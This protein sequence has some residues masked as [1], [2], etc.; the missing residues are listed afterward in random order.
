ML[1]ISPTP[2][3]LER[4]GVFTLAFVLALLFQ[5]LDGA[6]RSEYGGHPDEAAHYVTGL[7]VRDYVAAHLPG[8]PLTYAQQYYDHYP[9]IGLGVW[10]PFFYAVQAAWTLPFGVGHRALL[11]LMA[12][13][14]AG[15]GLLLHHALREEAGPWIAAA[16]ALAWIALPL[17]RELYGMVMAETLS[18][19]LM[20]G[21]TLCFGRFLDDGRAR[22]VLLFGLLAALAIMS[23]GTGL[24]LGLMA[25]FALILSRQWRLL[26][27]PALWGGAAVTALLA[28][29]WT[30]K[31]REL[32]H[33]GWLQPHPSWSFTREAIPYYLVKFT[34]VGIPLLILL[35]IGV[36]S[37]F[38]R[39]P[40]KCGGALAALALLPAVMLFQSLAPVGLEARHLVPTLP[41]AVLLAALGAARLRLP[42]PAQP[43]LLLASAFLLPQHHPKACGGFAPL[44]E[45]LIGKVHPEEQILVASDATGEGMLI[46][47]IALRDGHRPTYVVQRASKALAA[48]EW[49]GRDY[50]AKFAD[51]AALQAFLMA[52]PIRYVVLDDSVPAAKRTPHEAQL[53][54]LMQHEPGRF[55]RLAGFRIERGSV[56]GDA[57]LFRINEDASK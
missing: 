23:K 35:A 43:A 3:S 56:A 33:G 28:G 36:W 39:S 27:R 11:V 14:A 4:V 38:A 52:S 41:A 26:R 1:P 50:H 42:R 9:K 25:A 47:E 29:P 32:G 10:P 2:R 40:R 13:L 24:A 31:F 54:D 16:A 15:V 8:N 44:A 7:M 5:H 17:A 30:W 34:A 45:V 53:Q 51:E 37:L 20:F 46:S 49:S 18:A 6:D 57:W 19:L 55:S 22:D 48:S 12:V 21:A